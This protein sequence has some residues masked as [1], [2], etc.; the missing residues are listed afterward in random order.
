M[1]KRGWRIFIFVFN[2][3]ILSPGCHT[4]YR[5]EVLSAP[6]VDPARPHP[7]LATICVLRPQTFGALATFEHLD[8]GHLMGVTQGSRVYFC[9]LAEPGTHYLTARSDNDAT[10]VVRVG[11]GQRAFVRLEVRMG[12]DALA[13]LDD[14]TGAMLLGQLR[15]VVTVPTSPSQPPPYPYAAPAA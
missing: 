8:N 4:G 14:R 12:P 11:A 1:V 2:V 9:Y 10:A 3:L 13:P 5:V 15:Y 7:E 6:V